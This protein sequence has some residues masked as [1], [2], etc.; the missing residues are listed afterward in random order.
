MNKKPQF[1]F[2]LEKLSAKLDDS[3]QC[4]FIIL[5]LYFKKHINLHNVKKQ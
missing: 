1:T 3:L 2:A 4:H 5:T